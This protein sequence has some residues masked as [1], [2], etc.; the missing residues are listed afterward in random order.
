[1]AIELEPDTRKRLVASI[2]RYFEQEVGEEI[3]DLQAGFLLDFCLKE[4]CP[5]VYNQAIADAQAWMV[6]R[7]EDLEGSL[8]EPEF[9]F[10]QR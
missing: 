5:T 2:Q 10:W 8:F 6:G 1:M 9:G 3:G 7:V 4:I